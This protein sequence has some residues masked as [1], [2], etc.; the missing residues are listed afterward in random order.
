MRDP[1]FLNEE[2]TRLVV[3]PVR[4][5]YVHLLKPHSFDNNGKK[6]EP[7]YSAC[8]MIPKGEKKTLAAIKTAMNAAAMAAFKTTNVL[9]WLKDGDAK[10]DE[11]LHGHYYLNAKS[12]RRPSVV[13]KHFAAIIDEEEVYSG[14]YALVSMTAYSYTQF[15]DGV[16]FSIDNVMKTKDADRLGGGKASADR[17]F[18]GVTFDDYT[19]DDL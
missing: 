13:D 2:K 16:S 9:M 4:L 1:K 7:R 15:G 18:E 19:D 8:L 3:G 6:S 14:M 11:A 17:D 10:D 5:S 12:S